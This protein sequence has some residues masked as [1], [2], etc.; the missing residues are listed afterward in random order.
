[1][2]GQMKPFGE[3]GCPVPER[4]SGNMAFTSSIPPVDQLICSL[5]PT[6]SR[7]MF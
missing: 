7:P 3:L 1:M 4:S 6:H 5:V 2:S